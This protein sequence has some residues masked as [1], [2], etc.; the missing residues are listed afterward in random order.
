VRPCWYRAFVDDRPDRPVREAAD[1]LALCDGL[2]GLQR[3]ACVTA[4]SVV[5][6]PDPARQLA[7]C[8]E[9]GGQEAV[10]CIHGTKV[11]NLI[12]S[13]PED[14]VA[15]VLQCQ[16]FPAG[17]ALACYRWLGKVLAVLTNGEFEAFGCPQIPGAAGRRAC[18][19]GARSS[20]E[21][22]VT[23]S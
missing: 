19:D 3:Q 23:F 15:L 4:A 6:P 13:P 22:L 9:L 12:A 2:E 5:G 1:I 10:S 16:G 11:Q 20:D 17:T 18:R 8:N 7:I 21:P 14:L